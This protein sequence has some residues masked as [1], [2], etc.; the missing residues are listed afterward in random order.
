MDLGVSNA[1]IEHQWL[2]GA[3][4]VCTQLCNAARGAVFAQSWFAFWQPSQHQPLSLRGDTGRREQTKQQCDTPP[5][6]FW[7]N[8]FTWCGETKPFAASLRLKRFPSICTEN[9]ACLSVCID[10][11]WMQMLPFSCW[12]MSGCRIV[13]APA[14]FVCIHEA[15]GFYHIYLAALSRCF[16]FCRR[17]QEM[18]NLLAAW[19]PF[20]MFSN[21]QWQMGSRLKPICALWTA[22]QPPTGNNKKKKLL[23]ERRA[24]VSLTALFS[25]YTHRS[26]RWDCQSVLIDFSLCNCWKRPKLDFF[27]C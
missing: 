2:L 18:E 15:Y 22:G 3:A 23:L 10:T 8:W 5:L 4:S 16:C 24:L 1:V 25:I 7:P 21:F 14:T 13:A 17:P 11:L 12:V 6:M 9:T 27:F 26:S 20:A 19:H